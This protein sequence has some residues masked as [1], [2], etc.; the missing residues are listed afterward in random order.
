MMPIYEVLSQWK[1]RAQ[2]AERL[3]DTRGAHLL[4]LCAEELEGALEE[5]G[6]APLSLKEAAQ[7]SGYSVDH[8]RRQIRQGKI[9]NAG[10]K[11]APKIRRADL[12]RKAGGLTDATPMLMF[13]ARPKEQIARSIASRGG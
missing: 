13:P 7:E 9:Q 5:S 11:N 8:L 6:D 2:D 10:R 3:A 1:A 12:P 4:R